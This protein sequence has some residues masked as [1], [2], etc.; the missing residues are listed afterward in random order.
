MVIRFSECLGGGNML[1]DLGEYD[2][3]EDWLSA[4][5]NG[6]TRFSPL[7]VAVFINGNYH[8]LRTCGQ[9]TNDFEQTL[10][11]IAKLPEHSHKLPNDTMVIEADAFE[12]ELVVRLW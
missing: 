10:N 12:R 4:L 5:M 6:Q 9:A 3:V 1:A 2:K 11:K 8:S 7:D